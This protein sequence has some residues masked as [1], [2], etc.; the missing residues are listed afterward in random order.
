MVGIAAIERLLAPIRRRINAI[1][2]RCVLSLIDDSTM[3]QTVQAS[4]L[5]EDVR[6]G[7][8]KFGGYGFTSVPLEGAE[9]VVVFLKGNRD[10]GIIIQTEDRRYR[11]KDMDPGDSAMYTDEGALIALKRGKEAHLEIDKIKI[12]NVSGE[13]VSILSDTVEHIKNAKVLTL[14]GLQPL[15]PATIVLLTADKVKLDSF[16]V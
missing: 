9:G 11:P 1:V 4:F 15:D 16:K 8:E 12:E 5:K 6:E 10:H 3:A 2:G 14:M 7:L 13:L